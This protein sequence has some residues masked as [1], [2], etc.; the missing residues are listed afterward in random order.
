MAIPSLSPLSL[1]LAGCLLTT[2]GESGLKRDRHRCVGV[3]GM[4][5]GVWNTHFAACWNERHA[6]V[7]PAVT[8]GGRAP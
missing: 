4:M 1:Q 2:G 3:A 7:A 6:G 5:E 8:E